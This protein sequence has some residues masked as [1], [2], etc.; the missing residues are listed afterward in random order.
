MII[1]NMRMGQEK[2]PGEPFGTGVS[3]IK[4]EALVPKGFLFIKIDKLIKIWHIFKAK[5]T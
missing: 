3:A 1:L 4:A 2:R 5:S